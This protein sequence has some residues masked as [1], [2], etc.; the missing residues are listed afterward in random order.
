VRA[1]NRIPATRGPL[2]GMGGQQDGS[3]Q[4]GAPEAAAF[5]HR[6]DFQP[7][8]SGQHSAAFQGHKK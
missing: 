6:L 5:V 4:G 3:G 2:G 7:L 8:R 1:L